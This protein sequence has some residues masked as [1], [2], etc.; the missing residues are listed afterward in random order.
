M[1]NLLFCLVVV[2][3]LTEISFSAVHP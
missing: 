3:V 1:K 2:F